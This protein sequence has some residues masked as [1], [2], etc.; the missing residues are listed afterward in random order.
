MNFQE[1]LEALD[2]TLAS[3]GVPLIIGESGIGKTA[4]IKKYCEDN[5]YKLVSLDA[6]LLK[7]GEIGG[8][9]TVEKGRTIYATHTKLIEVEEMVK[10]TGSCL[11]FIDEINRCD[12]AVQQELMNLIL[13]REINGYKLHKNVKVAAAMNPSSRIEEF[14]DTNYQV[15]EMDPAQEN[16]FVWLKMDSDPKEWIIWGLGEGKI[17]ERVIEFISSFQDYLKLAIKDDF[18]EATPRSWE[19]VSNALKI[20]DRGG[21]SEVSLYNFVKGNV[22]SKIAGDFMAWLKEDRSK[23]ISSKDILSMDI[24]NQ[25]AKDYIKDASHSALY[26]L[27]MNLIRDINE[28]EERDKGTISR[29]GEVLKLYPRDLR[30]SIMKEVRQMY[31]EAIYKDLLADDEFLEAFYDAYVH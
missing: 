3:G 29:I 19:R 5:S 13:N 17:H 6:N 18:I 20:Y 30:I 22:G 31:K 16:R 2:L 1:T 4:L 12:H 14:R 23:A 24:I 9:P 11:L 7:E 27:I 28:V 8:L 25:R 21:Y 10:K 26:I 15:V